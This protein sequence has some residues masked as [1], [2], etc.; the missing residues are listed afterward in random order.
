MNE[1]TICENKLYWTYKKSRLVKTA[2]RN[3]ITAYQTIQPKLAYQIRMEKL[4][5]LISEHLEFLQHTIWYSRCS[6]DDIR[7]QSGQIY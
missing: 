5:Q 7:W 6:R 2:A 1:F 4:S 3:W